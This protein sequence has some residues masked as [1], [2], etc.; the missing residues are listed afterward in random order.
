MSY[1]RQPVTNVT[2]KLPQPTRTS[3]FP[4]GLITDYIKLVDQLTIK[5]QK[6]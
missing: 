1:D 4:R 2:K 6:T 3:E 5:A